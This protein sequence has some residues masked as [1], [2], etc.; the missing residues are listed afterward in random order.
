MTRKHFL[1]TFILLCLVAS[2]CLF[3]TADATAAGESLEAAPTQ[4][5]PTADAQEAT[6]S[7]PT[8]TPPTLPFIENL[9]EEAPQKNNVAGCTAWY[10]CVHGGSVSCSGP[11]GTCTSSGQGCGLVQCNG[12]ASFCPGA[13]QTDWNCATFC[14]TT[15]G[16]TDG[17]CDS[18]K[19]CVCN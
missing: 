1:F 18:L 11:T 14:Y 12:Q 7:P 8:K 4:V 9:L 19:C 6:A 13:C 16:S 3:A 15:Y 2:P 17:Y 5:E 10:P